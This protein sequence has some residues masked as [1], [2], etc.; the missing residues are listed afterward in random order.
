MV[1]QW[2][3]NAYYHTVS[4]STI[5]C[6]YY[7]RAIGHRRWTASA[8]RESAPLR[9]HLGSGKRYIGLPG[10]VNIDAH[11][12]Y[13][14]DIWLDLRLGLPFPPWSVDG[15]YCSH[16]LEHFDEPQVVA[17][18]RECHRVLKRGV[19]VRLVTP[20]LGKAIDAYRRGEKSYFSD[21]PD[22]RNS[23][24]GR[25]V[26]HM[27]CRDQHRLMFDFSFMEECL[28]SV[29]FT[30]IIECTPQE[31]QIFPLTDLSVFEYESLETHN[32]LFVEAF[33]AT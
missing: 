3:K 16:V 31:S 9:L 19:G 7:V 2:A 11:P 26:N 22:K 21:F 12:F 32:S 25:F 4:Q 10:Y 30:D 27:L 6:Y 28:L 5:V 24:G 29:G 15:I 13:K 8:S 33:R 23:L 14:K 18:L 17:L 20:H 1:P